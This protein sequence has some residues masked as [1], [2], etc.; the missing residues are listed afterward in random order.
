MKKNKVEGGDGQ[1]ESHK[2]A[3]RLA[4][5]MKKKTSTYDKYASRGGL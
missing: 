4:K 3:L 2:K 5:K 1:E